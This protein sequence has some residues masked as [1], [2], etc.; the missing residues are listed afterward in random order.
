[1]SITTE[2]KT[3]PTSKRANKTA[4]AP[5]PSKVLESAIAAP[6]KLR[7]GRC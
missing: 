3:K 6:P 5:S 2:A 1:M 4:E 7:V